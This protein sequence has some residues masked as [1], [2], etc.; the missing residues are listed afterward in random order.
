MPKIAYI[1]KKFRAESLKTIERVNSIIQ[2]YD[3]A[4]YSLT[5][6]QISNSL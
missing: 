3:L 2:E 5:L 4:G 1:E 6:I